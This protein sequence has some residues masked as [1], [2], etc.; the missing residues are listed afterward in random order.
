MRF[1]V[2]H[3]CNPRIQESQMNY[4]KKG[5]KKTQKQN[6]KRDKKK[7]NGKKNS[8]TEYMAV[9]DLPIFLCDTQI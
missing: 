8:R 9:C 7:T 5:K 1:T 3:E 2:P 4:L 6:R